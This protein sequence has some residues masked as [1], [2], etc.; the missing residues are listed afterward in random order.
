MMV[1]RL[2]LP[3]T[4]DKQRGIDEFY[5]LNKVEQII[6]TATGMVLFRPGGQKRLG[7]H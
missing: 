3:T 4:K 6:R 7:Q 2:T 5:L 1:T